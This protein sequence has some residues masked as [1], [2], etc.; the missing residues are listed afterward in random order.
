MKTIHI[1]VIYSSVIHIII[2]T[3]IAVK[4]D[5]K[6]IYKKEKDPIIY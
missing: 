1:L 2:D 5:M 6:N 4:H 3:Y